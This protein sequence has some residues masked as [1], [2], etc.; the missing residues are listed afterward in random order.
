L[1][2]RNVVFDLDGT[3]IDSRPGIVAGLRLAL[4]RLGH[5]LPADHPLDWAIGPPLA[6]VLTR[7]LSAFGDGRVEA[8]VLAYR[9][10]YGAVGIFDARVY[11]GVPAALDRLAA[12]GKALF[13]ATSKRA[14]FARKVLDHF[15]LARRFRSVHGADPEGRL[16][17]KPALLRHVLEAEG[18]AP[19]ETVVVGDREHD[20]SGARANGLRVVGAAWGYGSREELAGADILCD[21]PEQLARLL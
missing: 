21:S 13:V 7:L 15:G 9:E 12:S 19:G 16:S 5:E 3:L 4:G 20:V 14:D 17:G 2:V 6:E 8:A 18:L 1:V 11:P 10:W